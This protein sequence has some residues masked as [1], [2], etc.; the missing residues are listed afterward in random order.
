[1]ISQFLIF[2][3]LQ[4]EL[5][6]FNYRCVSKRESKFNIA[7]KYSRIPCDH[8]DER[9]SQRCQTEFIDYKLHSIV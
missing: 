6:I 9:T 4:S 3:P 1:M 2:V 5:E 8:E 7:W